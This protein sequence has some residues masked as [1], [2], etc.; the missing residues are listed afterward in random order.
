M[1]ARLSGRVVLLASAETGPA[2]ALALAVQGASVVAVA[3]DLE[4]GGRLAAEVRRAG[5]R[6][7]V[8]CPGPDANADVEAVVEL[9]AEL[10]GPD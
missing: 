5:G 6:A 9:V 3:P 1:G 7:A 2:L 4:A 10:G 8:F